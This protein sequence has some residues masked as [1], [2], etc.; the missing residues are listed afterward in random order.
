LAEDHVNA[1]RLAD[2][3]RRVDGL[4][5]V[6]DEIDTNMVIFE[7]SPQLGTAPEFCARLRQAGVWTL[8]LSP[9]RIRA[10]THLDV[11]ADDVR[12]AGQLLQEA[13]RAARTGKPLDVAGKLTYE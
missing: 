4:R 2:D 8:A 7:V 12:R 5:L 3:V 11:S 10:V 6:P 1:R 9:T 13:A